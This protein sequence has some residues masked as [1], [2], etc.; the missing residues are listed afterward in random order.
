MRY[1]GQRSGK[2]IQGVPGYAVAWQEREVS[3]LPSLI[4]RLRRQAAQESHLSS[5]EMRPVSASIPQKTD[6]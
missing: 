6:Q 5:Y 1:R 4:L 2:P 3:L